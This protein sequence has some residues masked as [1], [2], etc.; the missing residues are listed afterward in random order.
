MHDEIT[1]EV[2]EKMADDA[3]T[4]LRETVIEAGEVYL[5]KVPVAA[6]AAVADTWAEM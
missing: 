2:P 5:G 1:L 6:E 3:A 4:I